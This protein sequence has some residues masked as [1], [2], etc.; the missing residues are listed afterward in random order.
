MQLHEQFKKCTALLILFMNCP[1]MSQQIYRNHV[2]QPQNYSAYKAKGFLAEV[3]HEL[4][5]EKFLSDLFIGYP[6]YIM[7]P[8]F[9]NYNLPVLLCT[10][11]LPL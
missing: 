3:G 5:T 7:L 8:L 11:R 6:N 1:Q 4:H 9:I 10:T 2:Y